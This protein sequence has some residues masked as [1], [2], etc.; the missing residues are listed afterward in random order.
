MIACRPTSWN[1]M[2]CAEWRAV[3]AITSAA[4]VRSGKLAARLSASI[5]PIDPPTAA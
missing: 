2:F 4:L 3:A 1:A 5:P